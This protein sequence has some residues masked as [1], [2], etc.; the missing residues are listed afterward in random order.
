MPY[1][2]ARGAGA[3]SFSSEGILGTTATVLAEAGCLNIFSSRAV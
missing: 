2:Y 1:A 3:H